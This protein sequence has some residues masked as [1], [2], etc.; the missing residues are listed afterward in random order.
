MQLRQMPFTQTSLTS[1]KTIDKPLVQPVKSRQPQDGE[2]MSTQ[3]T[4]VGIDMDGVLY[5]FINAFRSYCEER[6]GRKFLQDPTH[7]NFFEDWGL[8]ASTF[9]TWLKEAAKSHTVFGSEMPY[10]TVLEAWEVLRANK[11]KIHILTARPQE[12]WGQTADWLEKYGLVVDSLHFNP[13]KDFLAKIATGKAALL[14]DHSVYYQEAQKA[15]IFACLL[16][17]PW[18]Q[19]LTDATRVRSVLEFANMIVGYNKVIASSQMTPI[20]PKTYTPL[21]SKKDKLYKKEYE[22]HPHQK[23]P[24][25]YYSEMPKD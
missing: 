18:N 19:D 13:T 4:D 12:A 15:G 21:V 23:Y 22:W 9:Q 2:N 20:V 11:I 16:N 1:Q 8:D 6:L 3:I 10:P 24:G 5:P 14:D 17:Q 25:Q 7:W